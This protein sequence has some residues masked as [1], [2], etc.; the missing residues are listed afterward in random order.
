VA[1]RASEKEN[2]MRVMVIVEATRKAGVMQAGEG[3]HPS[4]KGKRVVF[5]GGKK[6]VVE[7]DDFDR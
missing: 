7:A 2:G 6:T 4:S 5:S 1:F 3:L